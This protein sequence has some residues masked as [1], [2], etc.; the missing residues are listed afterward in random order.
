L[1]C[2]IFHIGFFFFAGHVSEVMPV[3]GEDRKPWGREHDVF[4]YDQ[5]LFLFCQQANLHQG[6]E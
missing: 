5:V 6:K 2:D 4:W 3:P 1:V